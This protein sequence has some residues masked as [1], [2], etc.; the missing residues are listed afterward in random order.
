MSIK[1]IIADVAV[2]PMTYIL[3]FSVAGASSIVAGVAIL[4]GAGFALVT[5]GVFL[6]ASAGYLTKGLKPNG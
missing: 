4:A 6:I 5:A 1:T 2:N 3:G